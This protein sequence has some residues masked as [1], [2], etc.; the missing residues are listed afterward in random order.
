MILE[1]GRNKVRSKKLILFSA[2]CFEEVIVP[3]W[4]LL[5]SVMYRYGIRLFTLILLGLR[6]HF[7]SALLSLG[8]YLLHDRL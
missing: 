6:D 1:N 8:T 2:F 5:I 3:D 4:L 7:T